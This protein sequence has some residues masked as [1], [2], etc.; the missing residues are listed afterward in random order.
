MCGGTL[1]DLKRVHLD[2][3]SRSSQALTRVLLT[4]EGVPEPHFEER[5]G[6]PHDLATDEG[7]LVI[8]DRA[9][10]LPHSLNT[11]NHFD[12]AELWNRHTGLPFVFA[13]WGARKEAASHRVREILE[14]SY[15]HGQACLGQIEEEFTRSLDLP[16]GRVHT[17]LTRHLHFTLD[18]EELEA[19]TLF[20]RLA[21]H[22]DFDHDRFRLPARAH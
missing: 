6:L 1:N 2:P 22:E 20:F 8:G 13:V 15:A 21:L 10:R 5:Q 16:P 18:R 12:L 3:A 4:M 17:Y 11:A 7:A 9:L 14:H 19:M